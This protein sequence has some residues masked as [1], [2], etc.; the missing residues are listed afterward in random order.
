MPLATRNITKGIPPRGHLPPKANAKKVGSRSQKN[1]KNKK[2]KRTAGSDS[3]EGDISDVARKKKSSKRQHV[4]ES[5]SELEIID[6]NVGAPEEEIEEVNTI[7]NTVENED[8]EVSMTF[9]D[10]CFD[11]PSCR[12]KKDLPIIRKELLFK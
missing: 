12:M 8:N 5:D 7:G 10:I 3:D 1:A 11:S 6:N 2:N 9:T 4:E